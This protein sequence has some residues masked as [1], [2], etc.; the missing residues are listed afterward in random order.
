MDFFAVLGCKPDDSPDTLR[1]AWRKL[2]LEHHPDQGGDSDKF[3]E[4]THAYRM[5][6]DPSYARKQSIRPVRDLTFNI[7]MITTFADA[8]YG[9]RLVV[10]YNQ[11]ILG[12]NLEPLKSVDFEPVTF[13]FD[14]PP[15]SIS[16]FRHV[17]KQK[18]KK[19]LNQTGDALVT[20]TA[21]KHP[22][23]TVKG[24]DVF[25]DENIKLEIMLK[26][27][28]ISVETL[29]GVKMVWVPPGTKPGENLRIVGGG[30]AKK[31]H[32]YCAVKPVYPEEKDLKNQDTWKSLGINWAKT[33]KQNQE[34]NDLFKKFEE[35]KK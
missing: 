2:C 34:D 26:G 7:Q 28:Y 21:E 1:K 13:A 6:T 5:I 9:T 23:Y 17:E 24:L 11:I 14:L 19:C 12:A 8:F 15:G 31:G 32:Q 29:W 30:V 18:G 20:V 22:R 33:D 3:V 10:S 27:D 35:M 16:G 4:V 25:V